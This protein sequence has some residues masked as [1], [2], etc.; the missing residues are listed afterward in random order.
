MTIKEALLQL[1]PE[2]DAQ[3]TEDGLPRLDVVQEMVGPDYVVTREVIN[4]ADSEFC[5]NKANAKNRREPDAVRKSEKKTAETN[6]AVTPEVLLSE[7]GRLVEQ[8]ESLNKVIDV[9]RREY[10][11][12]IERRERVLAGQDSTKTNIAYVRH[13]TRL[14]A[15][16]AAEAAKGRELLRGIDPASLNAKAPIDAAMARKNTRGRNRPMISMSKPKE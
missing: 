4:S 5:R 1:D 6:Q 2:N 8:R 16:K 15:A 9:K 11:R 13:Q 14:R 12:L 3:W 10:A 7:I